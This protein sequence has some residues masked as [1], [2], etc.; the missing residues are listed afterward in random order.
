MMFQWLDKPLFDPYKFL[1]LNLLLKKVAI[2]DC[3]VK[4]I[5]VGESKNLVK[6][7]TKFIRMR[8]DELRIQQNYGLFM[9]KKGYFND[10]GSLTFEESL[11]NF[12]I[13]YNARGVELFDTFKKYNFLPSEKAEEIYNKNKSE[14]DKVKKGSFSRHIFT[15]DFVKDHFDFIIGIYN[16]LLKNRIFVDVFDFRYM[17]NIDI[18]YGFMTDINGMFPRGSGLCTLTSKSEMLS[19]ITKY[20]RTQANEIYKIC[21]FGE[22]NPNVFPVFIELSDHKILLSPV[23]TF[24]L[25][26]VMYP[27]LCESKFKALN[28]KL[29]KDF[30]ANVAMTE[31]KSKGYEAFRYEK[32]NKLEIDV[33]SI[34]TGKVFV[35]ECKWWGFKSLFEEENIQKNIERDVKGIV[36]GKKYTN[37]VPRKVVS[38]PDKI[39]FVRNNPNEFGKENWS[40]TDIE[41]LILLRDNIPFKD[42]K[43]I[44][45]VSIDQLKDVI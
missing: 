32:K 34:K 12:V 42:Y 6:N 24:F 14:Y 4:K 44:K 8:E 27:I 3:G 17:R 40:G 5:E 25:Q 33:I 21:V 31:F 19:R 11:S 37:N 38:L 22:N 30:E 16:I 13:I 7:F 9:D 15:D 39:E 29:S 43:G 18:K 36:E 1:A 35:A 28:E 26:L 20:N 45:V 23:T 10:I 2:S 41:G